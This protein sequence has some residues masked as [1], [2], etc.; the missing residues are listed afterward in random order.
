MNSTI[1]TDLLE[2]E[3]RFEIWFLPCPG[4]FSLLTS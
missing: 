4:L 3:A 1:P 2:L